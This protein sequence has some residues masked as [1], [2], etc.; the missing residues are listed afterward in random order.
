VKHYKDQPIGTKGHERGFIMPALNRTER[1]LG[2]ELRQALRE[3]N[4]E[5]AT[6][7]AEKLKDIGGIKGND[8]P[9]WIRK[10]VTKAETQ[11]QTG[12][13]ALDA[14]KKV[15]SAVTDASDRI[16]NLTAALRRKRLSVRVAAPRI[17]V[18]PAAVHVGATS[19]RVTVG[20]RTVTRVVRSQT[21][22]GPNLVFQQPGQIYE[23]PN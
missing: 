11:G 3:G 21:A 20:A 13:E 6:L 8:L 14:T 9:G 17:S 19:V 12:K 22:Y 23:G 10:L 16:E 2:K 5:A 15:K 18:R 1:E 4:T 7:L